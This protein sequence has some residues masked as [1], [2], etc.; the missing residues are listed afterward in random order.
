MGTFSYTIEVGDPQ[1]ERFEALD[2][3]VD[4]GATYTTMPATI[5]ERLGVQRTERRQFRLADERVVERDVGQTWVRI[6]GRAF[7]RVVVFSEGDQALLGADSLEGFGLVVDPIGR[8]LIP[9]PGLLMAA[10]MPAEGCGMMPPRLRSG[11]TAPL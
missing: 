4:T 10:C 1:G 6:D 5:L 3:L 9:V 11:R 7:V 2:A 8:R